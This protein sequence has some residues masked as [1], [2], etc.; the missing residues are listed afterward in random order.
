MAQKRLARCAILKGNV[1]TA[2]L[3]MPWHWNPNVTLAMAPGISVFTAGDYYNHG[4]LS[5]Q[6]CLT[7]VLQVVAESSDK[8]L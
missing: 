1:Q 7:P 5:L 6:E 8:K 4:G 2:A 3:K